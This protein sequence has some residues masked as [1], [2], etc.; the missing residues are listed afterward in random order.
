VQQDLG[1]SHISHQKGS[2][3]YELREISKYN[4]C[5]HTQGAVS[6]TLQN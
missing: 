6:T 5:H 1:R 2:S 3:N 4:L